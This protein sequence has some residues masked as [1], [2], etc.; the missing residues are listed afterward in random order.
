V[1]SEAS[2]ACPDEFCWGGTWQQDGVPKRP[3]AHCVSARELLRGVSHAEAMT[4]REACEA[5]IGRMRVSSVP[6]LLVVDDGE[7]GLEVWIDAV[8]SDPPLPVSQGRCPGG[9]NARTGRMHRVVWAYEGLWEEWS[10][11]LALGKS[12][13]TAGLAR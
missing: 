6:I 10:R 5:V 4:R 8:V 2:A 1:T 7:E 11:G 3:V 12:Q 13:L 9:R